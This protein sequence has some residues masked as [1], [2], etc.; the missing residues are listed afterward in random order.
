[1]KKHLLLSLGLMFSILTVVAQQKVKDG[2]V[3]GS[4]LPNKDAILELESSNKG[5]LHVRVTLK[6]TTNAFPLTA[7]VAGMISINLTSDRMQL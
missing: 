1:M 6:A 4:N 2:T 5:L 7:H 3:T